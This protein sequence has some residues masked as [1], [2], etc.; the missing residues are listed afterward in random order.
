MVLVGLSRVGARECETI[1]LFLS[2]LV[3]NLVEVSLV[4]IV[5]ADGVDGLVWKLLGLVVVLDLRDHVPPLE[6][7]N[8]YLIILI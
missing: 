8:G 4:V 1:D 7:H 5:G 2:V 3:L 6:V